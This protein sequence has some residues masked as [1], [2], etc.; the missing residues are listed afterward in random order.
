MAWLIGEAPTIGCADSLTPD[1]TGL[2][3]SANRLLAITGWTLDE[4]LSVFDHRANLWRHPKQIWMD[5]GRRHAAEIAEE[6]GDAR[7]VVLGARAAAAFGLTEPFE[8]VGRFALCPHMA[9]KSWCFWNTPT[10]Q[11][12]AQAF[13]AEV[14]RTAQA[15]RGRR[16]RKRPA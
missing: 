14:R 3:R 13:F 16:A 9:G 12:R 2:P 10:A 8:W 15:V 11:S 1:E 4:F 7:V 6:S 5:E